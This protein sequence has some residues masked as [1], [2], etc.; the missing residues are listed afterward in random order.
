[1]TMVYL[2]TEDFTHT[3]LSPF[4]LISLQDAKVSGGTLAMR[5]L[6]KEHLERLVLSD[7]KGWPDIKVTLC[8]AGYIVIDGYH[9]WAASK[10]KQLKGLYA[11]CE[12]YQSENEIIEAAFR[13]NL[14]HGQQASQET[15]GDYAYWLH[16]M[17]P[18][19]EQTEIARRV[20]ISQAAVSKAIA[21][22]E[23]EARPEGEM[24]PE[25]YKKLLKKTCRRFMRTAVH[26]LD[27]VEGLED[28]ELAE[29]FN[30]VMKRDEDKA[31]FAQVA[32][33]LSDP[34]IVSL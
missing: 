7:P 13:A 28:Q 5:D 17:N 11:T 30:A 26:F 21:K 15:R 34:R 20:G 31:K 19:M 6:N 25:E 9:R 27:E 12:T 16:L 2:Q 23:Q 22:R 4:D 24:L 3:L 29:M 1:M 10:V 33:L 8:S 18:T 32:R 14:F